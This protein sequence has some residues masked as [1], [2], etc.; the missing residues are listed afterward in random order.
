[1]NAADVR[2]ALYGRWPADRYLHLYEACAN[3]GRQG[4]KIDVAV[5]GLWQSLKYEIDAIEVKCSV[6]DFRNEIETYH[7]RVEGI[8]RP[9][10]MRAQAARHASVDAA[11][12]T[13]HDPSLDKSAEWRQIAHRFWIAAPAVVAIKIRETLPDGWGLLAIDGRG[14]TVASAPARTEPRQLTWRET[15]GL[16]RGAADAGIRPRQRAYE[17]GATEGWRRAR[18][19]HQSETLPQPWWAWDGYPVR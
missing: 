3:P 5:I 10:Y 15:L 7:W 12:W 4:A 2:D 8:D 16:I 19:S 9:F 13:R 14:C 17:T 6:S 1:V 18:A 11:T